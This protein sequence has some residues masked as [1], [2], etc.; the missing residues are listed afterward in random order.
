MFSKDQ[1]ALMVATW[2]DLNKGNAT[3]TPRP[4][5]CAALDLR[6][7]VEM[8]RKFVRK[9]QGPYKHET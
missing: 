6:T 2:V 5:M 8:L 4:C 9:R 3:T 1:Q 7:L